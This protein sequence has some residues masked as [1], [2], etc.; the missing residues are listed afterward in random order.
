MT[1]RELLA[2]FAF[3]KSEEAFAQLVERHAGMVYSTCLRM[4]GTRSAAEEAAQAV[5]MVLSRKAKRLASKGA[6]AGWLYTTA[7][8][9]ARRKQ[10]AAARQ[11]R[12]E[13]ARQRFEEKILTETSQFAAVD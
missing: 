1:D 8:K 11:K 10:R 3:A 6:L 4:L 2:R 12:R 5:F 7:Y 9:V 13:L